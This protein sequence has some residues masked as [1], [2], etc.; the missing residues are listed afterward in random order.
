MRVKH[1]T[2]SFDGFPVFSSSFISE[3]Q[4]VLGGGGGAS[5]SG[6]KNKLRLYEIGNDLSIDLQNEFELAKGEDAP[7][8]M[9]AHPKNKEL[10][11]GVNSASEQLEKGLN[12]NCRVFELKDKTLSLVRTQ[13]TLDVKPG[14][15]DFQKVTVFSPDGTMIAAAGSYTLQLLSYPT[16]APIAT[17]V[18]TEQEIYDVTFST[19][20]VVVATTANLQVYSVPAALETND[21]PN[22]SKKKGKQKAQSTGPVT[23]KL[24]KTIELPSNLG[25]SSGGSFR[26][27]RQHPTLPEVLYTV[28][29]TAPAR[30]RSKSSP[31]QGYVCKW[32][33]KAWTVEKSRKVGDRGLTC[34][35]IS[36]DGKF[37]GYGSSD[38]SVGILDATTLASVSTIL[39]AHDFPP[40]TIVFNTTS[41]LLT[42]SSAD[43]SLRV[44]RIPD[45]VASSGWG[46]LVILFAILVLFIAFAIQKALLQ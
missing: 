44:V 24:E 38:L 26:S 16:L 22:K 41:K 27:V 11:C 3:N 15:D 25:G 30:T 12:E 31:R 45:H 7:M 28:I 23:L 36:P 17:P 2:H 19:D 6:I 4:V 8:S 39:K 40:T 32:D 29:N 34:F 35:S 10:A 37:L 43:N 1:T 13:G 21:S 9:A 42:S 20:K 46:F 33:T 18:T 5:K 14:D